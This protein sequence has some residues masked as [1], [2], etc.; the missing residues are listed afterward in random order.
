MPWRAYN[1]EN[2]ILVSERLVRNRPL[3]TRCIIEKSEI[4]S[5][6]DKLGPER[7]TKGKSTW[8]RSA[9]PPRMKLGIIRIG[10]YVESRRHPCWQGDPKGESRPTT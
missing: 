5:P 7:I 1:Y 10:A 8:L 3:H 6:P 4:E 2:A 9:S